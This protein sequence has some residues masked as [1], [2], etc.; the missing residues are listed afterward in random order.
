MRKEPALFLLLRNTS[1][2]TR[3]ACFPRSR[4]ASL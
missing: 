1:S 3:K 4:E 2:C